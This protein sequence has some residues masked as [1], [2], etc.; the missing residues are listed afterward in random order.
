MA[1]LMGDL[2]R[3]LIS[4]GAAEDLADKAATE[5]ATYEIRL[6]GTEARLSALTWMAGTNLALILLV[7]GVVFAVWSKL[8][9]VSG[10]I[11]AIAARIH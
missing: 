3:A 4:A 10:Q 2:R 9:E 5:I 1:I 11:A 8:G 7:A 6:A